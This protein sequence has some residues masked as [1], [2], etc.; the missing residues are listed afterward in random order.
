MP[1]SGSLIEEARPFVNV[2]T[3]DDFMTVVAWLVAAL[4]SEGEY[5]IL[6][7]QG[8]QGSGKSTFSRIL[9]SI[10]DP[11]MAPIRA[12]PKDEED[13]LVAAKN[14]H[15]IALDNL[16]KVDPILADALCRVSTGG[17]FSTRVKY[18]N[19]EEHVVW[20]RNPIL[21]NGIPSLANRPDLARRALI[22]HLR[23]I[24]DE[25]RRPD[26]VFWQE[27]REAAPGVLGALCDALSAALRRISTVSLARSSSMAYFEKLIE[28]AS[29]GLGW[30]SGTF[31]A[32]YA[33]NRSDLDGAAFEADPV[34]MAIADMIR[35]DYPRGWNGTAT[36]LLEVL[37]PHVPE[38]LKRSR[39]WPDSAQGLGNRIERVKPLLRQRGI[40]IERKHSGDRTISIVPKEAGGNP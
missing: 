30:E 15:V 40:I 38:G 16:S 18:T 32:A 14:G 36:R 25:E 9:R 21:I 26:D 35:D 8:E 20:A 29:P 33:A 37:A 31:S 27:W 6:I 23:S 7:I 17:G 1:Q 39:S 22:I 4:H 2:A 34:A 28:A 11:N 3:D 24:P 10:V 5:P 12:A 13:L 19:D